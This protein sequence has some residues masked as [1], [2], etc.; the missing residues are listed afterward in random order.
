M[1]E[2]QDE[3]DLRARVQSLEE[4]HHTLKYPL[5]SHIVPV[6]SKEEED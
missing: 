3:E 5:A 2:S 1:R 6:E 4:N